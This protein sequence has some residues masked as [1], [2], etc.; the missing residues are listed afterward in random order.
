MCNSTV[1]EI[2]LRQIPLYHLSAGAAVSA[3]I[4][5]VFPLLDWLGVN[6]VIN[7]L[8]GVLL[9]ASLNCIISDRVVFNDRHEL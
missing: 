9:G 1:K 8:T 7:T 5:I 6:Y 3:R 2:L 4:F